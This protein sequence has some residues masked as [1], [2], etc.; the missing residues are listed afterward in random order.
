MVTVWRAWQLSTRREVALKLLKSGV[1]ASE[2]AKLRFDR[3]VEVTGRLQHPNLA[4]VYDSGIYQGVYFYAMELIEGVS[5]DQY[6]RQQELDRRATIKL[7]IYTLVGSLLMLA[8]A[9]A[10]D[11]VSAV[12]RNAILQTAAPDEMRGRLGGVFIVVVAG[13]PRLGDGR[14][15]LSSELVGPQ[16]AVVAGGLLCIGLTAAC[17]AAVPRGYHGHSSSRR[18]AVSRIRFQ[19]MQDCVLDM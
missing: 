2:R 3:E 11:M 9:G 14:V 8:A 7:V 16:G 13:G 6:V 4:R 1:L 18:W 17:A 5:L 10:S 12:F 15:G 19:A